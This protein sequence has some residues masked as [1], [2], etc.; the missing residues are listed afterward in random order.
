MR[1]Q[2]LLRRRKFTTNTYMREAIDYD[3]ALIKEED[4]FITVKKYKKM[5]EPVRLQSEKEIYIDEGY[6]LVEVTPLKELYN[7]RFYFND[8]KQYIDCY[9]DISLKNGIEYNIPYYTDLYLDILHNPK[10]DHY[11]FTDEEELQEAYDKKR[12]S[13]KDYNIAY[14]VGNKLL[15]ELCNNKNPYRNLNIKKYIE[16]YF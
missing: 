14:K 8:K 2:E 4:I 7:M 1:K 10:T 13:K 15:E 6:Y 11:Y 16:E 5:T 3:I 12:I 9:I